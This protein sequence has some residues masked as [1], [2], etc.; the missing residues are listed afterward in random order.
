MENLEDLDKR[1]RKKKCIALSKE[2]PTQK[3]YQK[4]SYAFLFILLWNPFRW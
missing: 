4:H 1:R 3:E 2:N